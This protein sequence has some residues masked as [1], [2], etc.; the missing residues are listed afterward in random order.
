MTNEE[1]E[2][3]EEF[4]YN[5]AGLKLEGKHLES[6]K[7]FIRTELSLAQQLGYEKGYDDGFNS[8]EGEF[9][10]LDRKGYDR[11]RREVSNLLK[12]ILPLAKGY[13]AKNQ[14]GSNQKYIQE[15]EDFLSPLQTKQDKE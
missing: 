15:V 10:K 7:A 8:R 13:V 12:L 9:L 5:F 14:V 6:V 1:K 3:M 2:W 4:V 11:G